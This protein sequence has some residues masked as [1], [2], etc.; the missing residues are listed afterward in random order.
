MLSVGI[1][2][3]YE[4]TYGD[5]DGYNAAYMQEPLTTKEGSKC[6]LLNNE[7][8]ISVYGDLAAIREKEELCLPYRCG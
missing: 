6:L 4:S 3:M 7:T 8:S 5:T 1:V 2:P